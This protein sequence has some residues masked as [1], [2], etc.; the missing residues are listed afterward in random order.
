MDASTVRRVMEMI[1]ERTAR[2]QSGSAF[3]ADCPCHH[4]GR[5]AHLVRFLHWM[6]PLE[7]L[8]RED[9]QVLGL[10]NAAG[11]PVHAA[12]LEDEEG[13]PLVDEMPAQE[14]ESIPA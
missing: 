13:E 11:R 12:D 8:A 5:L 1:P 6:S 9:Q 4:A 3:A 14:P 10:L 2:Q 7:A